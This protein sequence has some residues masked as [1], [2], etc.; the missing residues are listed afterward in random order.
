TQT[1]YTV[2]ISLALIFLCAHAPASTTEPAATEPAA[3]EPAA[4]EPTTTAPA[5]D[6]NQSVSINGM[7][8]DKVGDFLG[9]KLKR[10]V[11]FRDEELKKKKITVISKEKLP[12]EDVLYLIREALLYQGIMVEISPKV[13]C[14]RPVGDVMQTHLRR[15]GYAQSVD[16]IDDKLEIVA[17]E[18]I[19]LHYDV[20]KMVTVIKPMLSDFAHVMADPDSA[21]LVVTDTVSNLLRIEQ[22]VASM[23]V[24][25]AE[26]TV[27][28]I[29]E[30]SNG[31]DAAEIVAIVRWLIAGKMGINV[32]DITTGGGGAA[33]GKTPPQPQPGPGRPQ[34]RP[35]R[36]G[37]D[38]GV[39]QIEP[40]KT[41]VTLVPHVSRNWIIA[42]APAEM[43]GQIKVWVAELDKP[44]Q[45]EKDY[46]L[47]DV[48][49]A[50][51]DD[52]ARQIGLV[53]RSLPNVE[54]RYT[55]HVV[56]FGKSKKV[57]VFGSKTGREMVKGLIEK[58]DIEDAEKRIHKIFQIEHADAEEMAER[59]ET[60]Y[61]S[62][63][64]A[65]SSRWGTSYRPAGQGPKVT[66]VADVRRNTVTVIAEPKTMKEV[67]KLIAEEDTPIDPD[68]VKP[69]IYELKYIDPGEMRDILS[70]MF[71]E[72][73]ATQGL[74]WWWGGGSEENKVKPVGRLLGQFTFH[75]MP[76][77][78]RLMV[79]TKNVANY[80]VID[81]LIEQLDQ[82]QTAGLPE[83]VELKYANAEDLCEQLNAM[84]AE[85]STLASVRRA[86]RGLS[87]SQ[88]TNRTDRDSSSGNP[89]PNPGSPA[90][91]DP[92][93]MVFWW[94]HYRPQADEVPT[95]NLIGNIRIVPVYDRN[96]LMV[97]APP[98]YRDA[99]IELVEKMDQPGR[100]VMIQA[101]IGEIQHSD[102]TTLGLRIASDPSLLAPA[103]TALGAGGSLSYLDVF[104]GT[105]TLDSTA[106]VSA[107][108]NLLIKKFDMKI[109]L[110]PTITTSDNK[111]SEYFDGSD[112]PVQDEM[113]QSTEGTST[114][115]NIRYI[116]VGTLLRVRPH[117]TKDKNV[118][119]T[120]N[121]AISRIAPG[122]GAFGNP[123]FDRR[124]VTTDVIIKDSQTIML[125]GIV[126][127]EDYE[128][129]RKV[130]L[131]GDIPLL[132]KLFRSVDKG[133]R[134][135]ELVLFITP[136]VMSNETDVLEQMAKPLKILDRVE[137]AFNAGDCLDKDESPAENTT[138]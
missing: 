56:P 24:A 99:I 85:P 136:R 129:I 106:S 4:T 74:P 107:L 126:Q 54:L 84:L 64:V 62:M 20:Q 12:I 122:S 42:V 30:L 5:D 16:T 100:Q 2:A 38:G 114:V 93:A 11:V 101:R 49:D 39:T 58:L 83:I 1:V 34:P 127:Q 52:I 7:T 26:G 53:I 82:R 77:S 119:L 61:S 86:D 46:E 135:R 37:G 28:E 137:N 19:V 31:G 116:N 48:K 51:A 94:Q 14:I 18:F 103:D 90:P 50:D 69:K 125:S 97:L 66:V 33:D 59:I 132:G 80:K 115:T 13:I 29:I 35:G 81:N 79:N 21:K 23:D 65:Y 10:A 117:I 120:I 96:A 22:V 47:F 36:P 57:I 134:N 98:G 112:V 109:L 15:V 102:Q 70:D 3:T 73:E 133:V 78:N 9:E 95:S 8:V 92:G 138:P 88:Q 41:P 72:K 55:T 124:E 63:E 89:G 17:K 76:S 43:M 105:L 113:K 111:A 128:E 118:A 75:V 91:A 108:L 104:G 71:S 87:D 110:E 32:K 60:L 68:D 121:L 6:N 123:I 130:P 131:L 40:S 67:E 27:T 25:L 45:V 44:R